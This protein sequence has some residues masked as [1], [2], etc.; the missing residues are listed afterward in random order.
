M[1][2]CIQCVIATHSSLKSLIFLYKYQKAVLC[3]LDVNPHIA[4][5]RNWHGGHSHLC[6]A[7][8]CLTQREH[9]LQKGLYISP[10][11]QPVF[12][13]SAQMMEHLFC[14]IQTTYSSKPCV[15]PDL[16][17]SI[18]VPSLQ[19]LQFFTIV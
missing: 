8:F 9:L 6:S 12:S 4:S 15:V 16:S 18:P 2:F 11:T 17:H 14:S 5:S 13:T 19:S 3:E 1:S 10:L 7:C